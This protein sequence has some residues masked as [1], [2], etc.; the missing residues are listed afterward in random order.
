MVEKKNSI[1]NYKILDEITFNTPEVVSSLFHKKKQLILKKLI[2]KEM[3]IYD[4][5]TDLKMNP[6]EI[7]RHILDL[8]DKGLILHTKVVKNKMG[9][10]LKYYRAKAKNYIVH[11]SWGVQA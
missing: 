7:R 1:E 10:K 8:L 9:M 4:L 3:T 2:K 11:L 6:G 5:K